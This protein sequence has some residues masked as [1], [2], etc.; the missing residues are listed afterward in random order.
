[1]A[2][3]KSRQV[4]ADWSNLDTKNRTAVEQFV[5]AAVKSGHQAGAKAVR[6]LQAA[7]IPVPIADD[8]GRVSWESAA[9]SQRASKSRKPRKP[10][11][12]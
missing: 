3:R 7:G 10:A 12:A 5:A 6:D 4:D 1:M 2:I 9:V 8:Q 11:Q